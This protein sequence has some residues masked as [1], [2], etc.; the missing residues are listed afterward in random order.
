MVLEEMKMVQDTTDGYVTIATV[1]VTRW[2]EEI[3]RSVEHIR[4][5]NFEIERLRARVK[6]LSEMLGEAPCGTNGTDVDQCLKDGMCC[7]AIADYVEKT[8]SNS[9][10]PT[11]SD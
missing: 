4:V 5:Q 3:E 11:G 1:S 7:C 2:M 6:K 10:G 9:N 8:P